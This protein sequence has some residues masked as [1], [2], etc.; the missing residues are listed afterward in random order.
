MMM[1][2]VAIKSLNYIAQRAGEE[3]VI[4]AG[5]TY[6]IRGQRCFFRGRRVSSHG[7]R[8]SAQDIQNSHCHLPFM[9]ASLTKVFGPLLTRYKLASAVFPLDVCSHVLPHLQDDAAAEVEAA[10]MGEAK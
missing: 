4:P 9:P 5:S 7:R 1:G 8:F 2:D 6:K 10:L 3:R